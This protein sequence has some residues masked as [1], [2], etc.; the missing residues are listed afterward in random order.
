MLTPTSALTFFAACI[1]L[2]LTPGPD[3]LFVLSHSVTHGARAGWK[4][5]AGLCCGVL[6]HTLAVA[7][8]VTALLKASPAAMSVL[9]WGGAAYLAYLAVAEIRSAQ[10]NH[11]TSGSQPKAVSNLWLRGF[12]MN[13]TNPKVALFFLAFLPQF[14]DPSE[15]IP[16]QITQLGILF[17]LSTLLVFGSIASLAG[18]IAKRLLAHPSTRKVM[19]YL[20]AAVFLGIAV[21]LVAS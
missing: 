15:S 7:L 9:Q 14:V 4:I 21:H 8:G 11:D 3:N 17:A 10:A 5:I 13:V 12:V 20:S 19:H 6:V 2:A 16:L 18:S 1:V